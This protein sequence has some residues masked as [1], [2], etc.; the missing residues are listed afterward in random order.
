MLERD[1]TCFAAKRISNKKL[2]HFLMSSL[3]ISVIILEK[4]KIRISLYTA[5]L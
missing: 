3:N 5:K 2:Q 4:N 1:E